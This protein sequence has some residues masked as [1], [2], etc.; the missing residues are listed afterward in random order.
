MLE[1]SSWLAIVYETAA[2]QGVRLPAA[3]DNGMGNVTCRS[4][5][6]RRFVSIKRRL[7]P[8]EEAELNG[9]EWTLWSDGKDIS[10]PVVRFRESL[11]PTTER[12][13]FIVALMSGWL[14]ENWPIDLARTYS[15]NSNGDDSARSDATEP[16]GKL[17]KDHSDG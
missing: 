16:A 10:D 3:T 15:G 12:A 14:V 13:R 11:H 17:G 7:V 8:A 6:G 5:N 2:D 9:I 1:R 4:A